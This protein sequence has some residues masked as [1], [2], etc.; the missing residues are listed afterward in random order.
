MAGYIA[1]QLVAKPL[2]AVKSKIIHV[3]LICPSIK[4]FFFL[5]ISFMVL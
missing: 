4:T 3:S 2:D 1:K 5:N